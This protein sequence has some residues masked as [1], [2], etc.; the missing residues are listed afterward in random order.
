MAAIVMERG[1]DVRTILADSEPTVRRALRLLLTQDLDIEVVG[2]VDA[3]GLLQRWV[4]QRQPDLIV[5]DWDLMAAHAAATVT[6]LRRSCPGLQVVV[7]GLRPELRRAALAAGADE[8][9]SKVD[10]PDQVLRA[11]RA[12]KMHQA[13]ATG[14]EDHVAF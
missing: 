11:L 12:A 6:A 10:A 3:L 7:L 13:K 5:V 4:K 2:E 9:A 14:G 8:F 1:T